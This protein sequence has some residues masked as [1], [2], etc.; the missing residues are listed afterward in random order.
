MPF[1]PNKITEHHFLS[2]NLNLIFWVTYKGFQ[3]SFQLI[4]CRL[5]RI[6]FRHSDLIKSATLLPCCCKVWSCWVVA[7][8]YPNI[9]YF[10]LFINIP[11]LVEGRMV[12]CFVWYSV[13]TMLNSPLQKWNE[14][15]FPSTF[16]PQWF[17]FIECNNSIVLIKFCTLCSNSRLNLNSVF[18]NLE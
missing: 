14:L 16:L 11:S 5:F 10:E 2:L 12:L 7:F 17:L 18:K 13:C 9:F 1:F 3:S 15:F 4:A 6:F 8:I